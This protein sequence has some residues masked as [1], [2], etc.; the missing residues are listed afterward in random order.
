MNKKMNLPHKNNHLIREI[1]KNTWL[2]TIGLVLIS[3]GIAQAQETISSKNNSAEGALIL[4]G[5]AELSG[6]AARLATDY[7]NSY[8]AAELSYKNFEASMREKNTPS[9]L[10][11]ITNENLKSS[12]WQIEIG[13]DVLVPIVNSKNP[14]LGTL[15]TLGV[16]AE[17]LAL[18]FQHAENRNFNTLTK[19]NIT[20][21]V[22]FYLINSEQIKTGTINF[23]KLNE[24]TGI[25]AENGADL[26][27][28]IQNDKNGI[29]FC[30]LSD[31]INI[32]TQEFVEGISILPLDL[33]NNGKMDDFEQIY[34]SVSDFTRAVWIGKYS[35]TLSSPVYLTADAVPENYAD[36]SLMARQASLAQLTA[37]KELTVTESESSFAAVAMTI[38][39]L[40]IAFVVALFLIPIIQ[41][42][43]GQKKSTNLA[44]NQPVI[45]AFS[46][47]K[48]QVP[49][50]LFFDKTHT[51]AFM[52]KDGTVKIGIDDFLQHTTGMLT[53]IKMKPTGE[54]RVP[55][56]P[57]TNC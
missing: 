41:M 51:W 50:G 18:Y 5:T 44:P 43:F 32:E 23:L 57:T 6:L 16:S 8:A 46:Q 26:V 13:H 9:N 36:L 12:K 45:A 11:F 34:S 28:K 4:S 38:L 52:E 25:P 37:P 39:Y 54:F 19:S 48:L 53:Q 33:N 7:S 22:N 2:F 15:R 27:S 40:L 31:I 55:L 56:K 20:D 42:L 10:F 30:K 35:R 17:N 29:G 1:M 24:I 49:A 21:A 47:Q 14:H 3:F